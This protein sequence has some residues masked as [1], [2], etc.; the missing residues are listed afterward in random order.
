[1]H[2]SEHDDI[3]VDCHCL[4]GEGQTVADDVGYAVE[5]LGRLIIVSRDHGGALALQRENG[6]DIVGKCRPLDQRNQA[7][8]A[9]LQKCPR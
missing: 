9:L 1:M 6:V 2:A 5:N 3:G 8:D 7:Q 4:P